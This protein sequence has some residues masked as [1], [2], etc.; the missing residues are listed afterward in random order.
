MHKITFTSITHC[1][2]FDGSFDSQHLNYPRGSKELDRYLKVSIK[3]PSL[4]KTT[5]MDAGGMA[6]TVDALGDAGQKKAPAFSAFVT[7]WSLSNC[8]AQP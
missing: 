7:S 8:L 4:K 2:L 1:G 3:S 5:S 6:P